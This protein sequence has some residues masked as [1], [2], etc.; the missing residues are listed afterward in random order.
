MLTEKEIAALI[1]QGRSAI[2][3]GHPAGAIAP[4][5]QAL[6]WDPENG[7]AHALLAGALQALNR[8]DAALVEANAA[9]GADPEMPYAHV[10][11]ADVLFARRDVAGARRHYETARELGPQEGTPL[12]GLAA[13]ESFEDRHAEAL[14]LLQ[15]AIELEP[16]DAV[17]HSHLASLHLRR[18]DYAQAEAAARSALSLEPDQ[19]DGLVT[20]GHVLLHRGDLVGA[21]EH[22]VWALRNDATNRE[23]ITLLAGVKA[24]ESATLGLWYRANAAIAR[25]GPKSTMVL[26]GMFVAQLFLRLVLHDAGFPLLSLGLRYA[27]LAVC[28]YSWIGPPRFEAM[29]AEELESVRIDP[30]Y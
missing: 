21:R 29:I 28:V 16:E 25:L 24:R 8:L 13:I 11:L 3:I 30:K 5:K 7:L 14:R 17:N 6:T 23:A 10:V 19:I 9:I 22:A 12:R 4:L 27:W 15:A 26:L 18:G 1:E 2:V 20:I